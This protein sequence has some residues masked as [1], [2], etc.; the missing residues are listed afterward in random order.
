MF[1]CE[2]FEIFKNTF[3][4][5]HLRAFF[6]RKI[7]SYWQWWCGG[8]TGLSVERIYRPLFK[9]QGFRE[10]FAT[11]LAGKNPPVILSVFRQH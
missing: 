3:F 8:S 10:Y 7:L 11:V 6:S 9:C 1:S 4:T 2:F 5:K